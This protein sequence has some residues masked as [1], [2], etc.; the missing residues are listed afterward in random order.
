MLIFHNHHSTISVLKYLKD[1]RNGSDWEFEMKS[2]WRPFLLVGLILLLTNSVVGCSYENPRYVYIDGAIVYGADGEPIELINNPNATCPTYAELI[3]FIREDTSDNETYMKGVKL[4]IKGVKE[5]NLG[6]ECTDFAENLHNNAEAKGIRAAFVGIDIIG[7]EIGHAC[8]AFET[9]DKG[10]VYVDC[11]GAG[12]AERIRQSSLEERIRQILGGS[13]PS[14]SWDKIAYV[15]V[16]KEYGL[17]HIDKAKSP[18][19][20]F[21]EEYKGKWLKRD[22]LVN[23]YKEE[24]IQC[25]QEIETWQ[26]T[27]YNREIEA[28]EVRLEGIKH[29]IVELDEELDDFW[30]EPLGIVEDIHIYWGG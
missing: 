25:T 9:T 21:Y 7:E 26:V 4:G 23:M 28:C 20:S 17:I 6:R 29:L 30:F 8:N 2:K 12:F 27:K 3:A 13:K 19:Y 24:F 14:S 15:E 22:I 10:L 16:F 1:T 5:I 18:S 11:V